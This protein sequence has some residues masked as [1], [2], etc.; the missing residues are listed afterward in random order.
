M[1]SFTYTYIHII[2]NW[3][4]KNTWVNTTPYTGS[5]MT[6]KDIM[7]TCD[8][9]LC[10]DHLTQTILSIVLTVPTETSDS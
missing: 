9:S 3:S 4:L 8:I 5:S 2:T 1:N 7:T 6:S 10:A